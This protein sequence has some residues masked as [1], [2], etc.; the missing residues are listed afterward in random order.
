M[1][2]VEFKTLD[3]SKPKARQ[4]FW[5]NHLD[6]V[7][8]FWILAYLHGAIDFEWLFDAAGELSAKITSGNFKPKAYTNEDAQRAS[9]QHYFHGQ[10]M[11]RLHCR[12]RHCL[13][14]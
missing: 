9:K 5:F 13:Y 6:P 7:S 2:D 12:R 4:N 10:D 1:R 14:G 3:R 11:P 8:I